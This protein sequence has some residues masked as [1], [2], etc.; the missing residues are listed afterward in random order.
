MPT[1]LIPLTDEQRAELINAAASAHERVLTSSMRLPMQREALKKRADVI[2]AAQKALDPARTDSRAISASEAEI[3]VAP[4]VTI[5]CPAYPA[6]CDY[7]RVV[8][9]GEE[10]AYW[11]CQEWRDDMPDVMGALL[12]VMATHCAQ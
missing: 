2:K 7:V 10:V 11:D 12:G 3:P 8:A 1:T 5:C 6:S 9:H 4:G